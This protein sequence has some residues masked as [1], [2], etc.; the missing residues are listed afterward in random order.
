MKDIILHLITTMLVF[1]YPRLASLNL[2]LN[3]VSIES[4]SLMIGYG[5]AYMLNLQVDP[6]SSYNMV[7]LTWKSS[8]GQ[9]VA[10]NEDGFLSAVG[11]GSA[12]ITVAAS[13]ADTT[14]TDSCYVLVYPVPVRIPDTGFRSYCLSFADINADFMLTSDELAVV[15][16]ISISDG[17]VKSLE[18][19]KYFTG[20]ETLVCYNNS[21]TSLDVSGNPALKMILC[22]NNEIA[23]LDLSHNSSLE[24]IDC[25]NNKLEKLNLEGNSNL[26]LVICASNELANLDVSH[27]RLLEYLDCSK[28]HLKILDMTGNR[29]LTILNCSDN[30]LEELDLRNNS[31]LLMLGCGFNRLTAL[32]VSANLLLENLNCLSNMLASLDVSRNTALLRLNCANNQLVE[33]DLSAHKALQCQ[34]L[35]CRNNPWLFELWLRSKQDISLYS[36]DEHT[37]VR[38][39]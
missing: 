19:L 30:E 39:R 15:E 7:D 16:R 12:T 35:D 1:I 8:D 2:E 32:D 36:M 24:Y 29:A 31:K 18:G 5:A 23:T 9:I 26:A 28:N 27:N 37:E 17:G 20:L 10:V 34:Y 21:L 14:C 4:D 22:A 6:E 33:L 38:Y 11:H 25:G 3:S 13:T